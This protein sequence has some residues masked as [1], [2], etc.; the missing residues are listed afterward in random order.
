M[1]LTDEDTL[2]KRLMPEIPRAALVFGGG[3]G[4][5]AYHAGAYAKFHEAKDGNLDWLVGSSVGAINAALIAGNPPEQRIARLREFWSQ[6][7]RSRSFPMTASQ[8]F[9]Y[10]QNWSSA[11]ETRLFGA[12]DYFRP[13]PPEMPLEDFKSIYDLAPMRR[14]LEHLIDFTRLNSGEPRVTVGTTDIE[15]GC[16]ILFDTAREKLTMDH[17]MASCGMLPEFAPVL[18]DGRF[19]GDGGLSA[20]VPFE[21]VLAD[22]RSRLVFVLDL[23]ARDGDRPRSLAAAVSRKNELMFGNQ[24]LRLLE[25]WRDKYDADGKR[26]FYLSH[27]ALPEEAD[28]EKLFDLS[29]TTLERRWR[30]GAEDMEVALLAARSSAQEPLNMIRKT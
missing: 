27:R 22:T 26:V 21:P 24:T 20:N 19:L 23:F 10:W 29:A 25:F 4:L 12:A 1:A 14:S 15:T 9:R 30:A 28:A 17:L 6:P 2:D 11:I 16:V 18:I 13:R 7:T 3:M 5:G 8:N